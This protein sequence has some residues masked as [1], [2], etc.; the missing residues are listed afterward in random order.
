MRVLDILVNGKKLCE[1]NDVEVIMAWT[2]NAV[3][4]SMAN[5]YGA[6]SRIFKYD[7]L[8]EYDEDMVMRELKEA[9]GGLANGRKE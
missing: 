3:I 6:A 7:A 2:N 1:A 5:D 9:Y 4:V 8:S